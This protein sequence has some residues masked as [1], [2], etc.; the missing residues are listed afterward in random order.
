MRIALVGAGGV[1]AGFGGY[2]A[3]AGH[4]LV[5]L[6]RGRHLEAIQAGGLI[7]RRPD[8]ESRVP[9]R[10]SDNVGELGTVDLVIFAVKLWD[11]EAAARQMLP[12]LG[13]ATMVLVLQNGV[14]ALDLLAPAVGKERLIGG[15]AQISAVIEAP[16]VVAHRSPFARIIAGEPGAS[17]SDRLTRLVEMMTQAGIDAQA[18]TQIQVD[19]WAKFV[20]IVGLSGTTAL[21]RAPI[22]PIRKHDRT[23]AFLRALVEEAVAVAHAEGVPLPANQVEQTMAVLSEL[24]EG[25]K[26]SM[27]EDLLA[28]NRLEL[29]WLSG[30]VVRSGRTHG[31][32]TPANAAV[33]LALLLHTDGH[34][35]G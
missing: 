29:P 26:A 3:E 34:A 1:G 27:F 16:G 8:G 35:G 21:F 7:V 5:A 4:E 2:L 22:G 12:M 32:P 10:A 28:G 31:I 20:F 24:P 17:G 33:E 11:T 15:V 14:D 18:S 30:R 23:A 6:A 25:M 19:L 9:V 13:E